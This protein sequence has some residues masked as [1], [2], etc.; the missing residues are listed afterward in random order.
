VLYVRWRT[1]IAKII[2]PIR[3]KLVFTAKPVVIALAGRIFGQTP[4][5]FHSDARVLVAL[6]DSAPTLKFNL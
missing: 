2:K 6:F 5:S 4:L 3:D 1:K